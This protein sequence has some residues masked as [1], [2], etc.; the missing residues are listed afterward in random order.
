MS[1]DIKSI[2]LEGKKGNRKLQLK[3]LIWIYM[4]MEMEMLAYYRGEG[5]KKNVGMRNPD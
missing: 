2:Q 5:G 1:E 4:G 3:V